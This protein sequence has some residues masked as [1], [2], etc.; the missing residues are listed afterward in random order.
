MNKPI[1]LFNPTLPL[2]SKNE[3]EVLDLL[4]E[5][6]KLIAPIYLEQENTNEPGANFYP[7]GVSREEIEKAAKLTDNKEFAKGLEIQAKA[8]LDGSYDE[9]TVSW[10]NMKSY[11]LDINIGPVERYDDRLFFTKTSYQA[12][13]GVMDEGNTKRAVKYRD[14]IF[15]ARR[16]V[17][18][19]SEKVDF[20]E[21]VQIRVDDAILFYGLIARTQFVSVNL[22]NDP[23]FMEKYGSEI[24]IFKQAAQFRSKQEVL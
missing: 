21:K 8:L 16:K 3:R 10:I 18:I 5:A 23:H 1:L 14:I 24:T 15:S 17:L 4:I 13:V 20:Y 6:G 9:A 12:W 19:P 22:P 11:V 2:L 7:Q